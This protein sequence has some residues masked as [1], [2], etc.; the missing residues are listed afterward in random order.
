M[1][2]RSSSAIRILTSSTRRAGP[3]TSPASPEPARGALP[4]SKTQLEE[5]FLRCLFVFHRRRDLLLCGPNHRDHLQ[6]LERGPRDPKPLGVRPQVRRRQI[7][8]VAGYQADV[9]PCQALDQVA[10]LQA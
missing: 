6:F 3:T 10:I 5:F 9:V 8:A 7:E 2:R 4:A 1:S